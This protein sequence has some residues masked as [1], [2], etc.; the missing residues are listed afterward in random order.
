MPDSTT[1]RGELCTASDH[2]QKLHRRCARSVAM[3]QPT[4]Y[5]HHRRYAGSIPRIA[6]PR[7]KGVPTTPTVCHISDLLASSGVCVLF[8]NGLMSPNNGQGKPF[9]VVCGKSSW[10][11]T[12]WFREW[13]AKEQHTRDA[14]VG[15]L[16]CIVGLD[17]DEGEISAEIEEAMKDDGNLPVTCLGLW[18]NLV[19]T[20]GEPPVLHT[21]TCKL[22]H[23]GPR[24]VSPGR[25]CERASCSATC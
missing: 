5:C 18:S 17:D 15:L 16:F 11:K 14:T 1:G 4:K 13:V 3:A 7:G 23:V 12:A 20:A 22:H 8:Y 9:I 10:W 6:E 25:C 21:A 24:V 19:S 2:H